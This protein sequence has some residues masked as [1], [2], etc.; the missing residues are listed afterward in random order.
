LLNDHTPLVTA[1]KS[2]CHNVNLPIWQWYK[3]CT[4]KES[5]NGSTFIIHS[6]G[7]YK[8]YVL[9]TWKL[10][11]VEIRMHHIVINYVQSGQFCQFLFCWKFIFGMYRVYA[12]YK[13]FKYKKRSVMVSFTR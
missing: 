1:V 2:K 10:S 6:W 3:N 13:Y 7:D 11:E 12:K 8:L 9:E 4:R 5:H